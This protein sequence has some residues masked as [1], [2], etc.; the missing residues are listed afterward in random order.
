MVVY[1]GSITIHITNY[2]LLPLHILYILVIARMSWYMHIFI[3]L[4]CLHKCPS[5]STQWDVKQVT[6]IAFCSQGDNIA[7]SIGLASYLNE[8]LHLQVKYYLFEFFFSN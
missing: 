4:V 2:C 8:W 3:A 5:H 1:S 6:L 7:D